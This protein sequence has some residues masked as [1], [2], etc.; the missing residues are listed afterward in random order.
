MSD[1][2][3]PTQPAAQPAAEKPAA[4]KP[5]ADKPAK[6][7]AKKEKPPALED[8]PFGEFIEQHYLP[9]LKEALQANGLTDIL[10]SFAKDALPTLGGDCWQVKGSWASGRRSFL[11]A[12]SQEN[13]SSTKAFAYAD[14]G[15]AP[16]YVEPFLI[17]ER[18]VSLPMLVAGVIQRL[19][20]Q[21]WLA[22][23]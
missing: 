14:S 12:F 10:L 11:I 4:D 5:A 23:N 2:K 6:A 20:G 15:V 21:K 16:S 22:R 1:E 18:K 8:K 17:D 9:S 3:D 13:I 19:N 7:P